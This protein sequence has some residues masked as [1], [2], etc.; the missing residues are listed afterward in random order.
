M[1]GAV[2]NYRVDLREARDEG[3]D[4]DRAIDQDKGPPESNGASARRPYVALPDSGS[5]VSKN[6]LPAFRAHQ[7][8]QGSVHDLPLGLEPGELARLAD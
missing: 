7:Q 4:P 2:D 3:I 5:M 8:F 1:K 6:R